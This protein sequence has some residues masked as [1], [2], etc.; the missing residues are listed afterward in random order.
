MGCTH[1]IPTENQPR[2][3]DLLTSLSWQ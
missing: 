3:I 1:C 2:N